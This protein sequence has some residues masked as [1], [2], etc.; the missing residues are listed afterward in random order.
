MT[1]QVIE[2]NIG[3]LHAS[4]NKMI[5][6]GR[7]KTQDKDDF[8]HNLYIELVETIDS[9]YDSKYALSTWIFKVGRRVN[10][11]MVNAR[12]SIRQPDGSR[13]SAEQNFDRDLTFMWQEFCENDERMEEYELKDE[14]EAHFRGLMSYVAARPTSRWSGAELQS[15]MQTFIASG[16]RN[17]GLRRAYGWKEHKTRRVAEYLRRLL[18]GYAVSIND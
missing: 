8:I 15:Y 3:L 10:Q 16:C 2:N 1:I 5:N 11:R 13:G 12:G 7:V 18:K 14:A 4:A 9:E 17:V 6:L